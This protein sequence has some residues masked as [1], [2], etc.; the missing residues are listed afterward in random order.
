MD[1]LMVGWSICA[2]SKDRENE[3]KQDNI[4]QAISKKLGGWS[5]SSRL[6]IA[7]NIEGIR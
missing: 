7:G 1:P 3:V 5:V 6:G 4:L 2:V